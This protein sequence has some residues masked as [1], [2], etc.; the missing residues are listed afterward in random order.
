LHAQLEVVKAAL[1]WD[2]YAVSQKAL[3]LINSKGDEVTVSGHDGELLGVM[4]GAW[5]GFLRKGDNRGANFLEV[6]IG[7]ELQ[8]E[9]NLFK[10]Y[11]LAKPSVENDTALLKLAAIMTHNVGD[12]DQGLSSWGGAVYKHEAKFH[13]FA[14]LAHQRGDRFGGEFI[15]AKEIYKALVSAEGHR[16]YPLREA[17]GLRRDLDLALPLGP[18]YEDWG[19]R[20]ATHKV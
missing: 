15:R 18:W 8:R 13:L 5:G 10:Q 6:A 20:V 16:N 9:A 4:S 1:T 11:R 14:R 12:V 19:R 7:Q 2:V 3:R 17:R